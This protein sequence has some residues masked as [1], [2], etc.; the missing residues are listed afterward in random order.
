MPNLFIPYIRLPGH[1]D[2]AFDEFT[3]GDERARGRKL[4]NLKQGDYV[5]FHTSAGRNRYVTAYYVVE[6]IIPTSSAMK[7]R[8]IMN[9]YHNPHLQF[10]FTPTDDTIL[11]GDPITS[12]KFKKPLLFDKKLARKL[13][14]GI[15]FKPGIA[16]NVTLSSATRQWRELSMRD[17]RVLLNAN[18]KQEKRAPKQVFRTDEIYEMLETDFENYLSRYSDLLEPG[19]KLIRKQLEMTPE[20]RIDLLFKKRNGGYL[21]VELK[22]GEIGRDALSQLR[23]YMHIVREKLGGEVSGALVC[24]GVLPAF[25]EVARVQKDVQVFTYEW[26]LGLSKYSVS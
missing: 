2:P 7:D 15:R 19:L 17:V 1:E 12:R 26:R 13:S 24:A 3:Y 10:K 11:F 8:N 18:L 4:R 23:R 20:D 5:F 6:R 22:R 16:D 9:K 14:L 25:A 21:V